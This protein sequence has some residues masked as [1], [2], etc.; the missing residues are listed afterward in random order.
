MDIYVALNLETGIMYRSIDG[1]QWKRED[2]VTAGVYVSEGL[3]FHPETWA[4]RRWRFEPKNFDNH[5]AMVET[6]KHNLPNFNQVRKAFLARE[7]SGVH[8]G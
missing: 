1:E 7:A 8:D 2:G 4:M 6:T 3:A 5:L